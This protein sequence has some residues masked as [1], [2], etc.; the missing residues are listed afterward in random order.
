M[1]SILS[2][3]PPFFLTPQTTLLSETLIVFFPLVFFYHPKNS[4]DAHCSPPR[5]LM[6][7]PSVCL[8][9]CVCRLVWLYF[10]VYS[11]C[12]CVCLHSCLSASNYSRHK[13]YIYRYMYI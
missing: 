12:L 10:R 8:D 9:V 13:I 1:F 5:M 11:L 7:V 3:V 6:C 2:C 4:G